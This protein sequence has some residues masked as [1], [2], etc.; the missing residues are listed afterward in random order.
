MLLQS[1]HVRF[2]FGEI[3]M[4]VGNNTWNKSKALILVNYP[5]SG[6]NNCLTLCIMVSQPLQ[7][8]LCFAGVFPSSSQSGDSYG[9]PSCMCNLAVKVEL[10]KRLDKLFSPQT[11]RKVYSFWMPEFEPCARSLL[12]WKSTALLLLPVAAACRAHDECTQA[13]RLQTAEGSC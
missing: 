4:C 12:L 2:L 3:Q 11:D 10:N 5:N 1:V 7:Q 9:S 8:M 6:M 13:G